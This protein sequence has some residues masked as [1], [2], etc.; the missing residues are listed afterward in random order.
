MS[1]DRPRTA[2]EL[3]EHLVRSNPKLDDVLPFPSGVGRVQLLVLWDGRVDVWDRVE[4]LKL[5]D[6][7]RHVGVVFVVEERV[8]VYRD[9]ALDGKP[10]RGARCLF[11]LQGVPLSGGMELL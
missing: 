6:S 4:L 10:T 7:V 8:V 5:I 1:V 11:P 3:C 2:W 9:W